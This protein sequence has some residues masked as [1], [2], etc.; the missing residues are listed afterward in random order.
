MGLK[1]GMI[2]SDTAEPGDLM[3]TSTNPLTTA[4][5]SSGRAP[6]RL[7]AAAALALAMAL[8]ASLAAALPAQ[9]FEPGHTRFK[10]E[11]EPMGQTNGVVWATAIAGGRIYVGGSFTSTRPSGAAQGTGETGQSYLAAFDAATGAPVAGFAP[12]LTN[13]WTNGPATV[14]SITPSADGTSIYVGGDFN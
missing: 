9:A 13:D 2:G 6:S 8:I 14:W 10:G 5:L 4:R 7:L 11:S 3:T 12:K 1:G